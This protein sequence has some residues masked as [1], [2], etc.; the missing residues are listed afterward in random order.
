MCFP[1][2]SPKINLFVPHFHACLIFCHLADKYALVV[3]PLLVIRS[4]NINSRGREKNINQMC[5][6]S[7]IYKQEENILLSTELASTGLMSTNM[8]LLQSPSKN[9]VFGANSPHL[10]RRELPPIIHLSSMQNR[11]SIFS[12][13]IVVLHYL[14]PLFKWRALLHLTTTTTKITTIEM[15][16]ASSRLKIRMHS[17]SMMQKVLTK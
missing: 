14:V 8:L 10:P 13:T 12:L 5:N 17:L 1:S 7:F 2:K 16:T 15:T 9:S 3:V 6:I 4:L 11:I